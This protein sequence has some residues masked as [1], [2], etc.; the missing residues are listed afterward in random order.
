MPL[1]LN[2]LSQK[3]LTPLLP[4]HK[5]DG[6]LYNPHI[7]FCSA[8]AQHINW[9]A[10]NAAT[11]LIFAAAKTLTNKNLLS[12]EERAMYSEKHS[13]EEQWSN[14]QSKGSILPC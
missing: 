13:E 14:S 1:K 9:K 11:I 12:A 3:E 6:G 2:E 10:P 8:S 7:N 5:W 4:V